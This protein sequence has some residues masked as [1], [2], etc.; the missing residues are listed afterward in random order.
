MGMT[1]SRVMIC[2]RATTAAMAKNRI[3]DTGEDATA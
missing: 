3:E 2:T 1:I